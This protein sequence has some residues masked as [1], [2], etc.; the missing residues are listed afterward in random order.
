MINASGGACRETTHPVI[1]FRIQTFAFPFNHCVI[2]ARIRPEIDFALF[3]PWVFKFCIRWTKAMRRLILSYPF[4]FLVVLL[5][6]P[7]KGVERHRKWTIS[8][9][10]GRLQASFPIS[11]FFFTMLFNPIFMIVSLLFCLWNH[12]MGIMSSWPW[13]CDCKKLRVLIKKSFLA[14]VLV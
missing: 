2:V 8:A 4:L 3:S 12:I 10:I 11:L 1:L 9:W 13:C 14:F 6:K 7:I 5:F